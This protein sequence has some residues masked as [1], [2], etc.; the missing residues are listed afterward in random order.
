MPGTDPAFITAENWKELSE[1]L[2]PLWMVLGAVLGLAVSFL[3]AHGVIPSLSATR[4]LPSKLATLR[5]PFYGAA[6]AFLLFG[7]FSVFLLINRFGVIAE[8]FWKGA[9]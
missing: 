3:M 7:L 2:Y 4:D 9:V 1:L 5:M 6:V 8:I